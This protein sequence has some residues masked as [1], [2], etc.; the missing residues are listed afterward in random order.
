MKT[1][2]L[3]LTLLLLI[4]C[5]DFVAGGSSCGEGRLES[6]QSGIGGRSNKAQITE[7][8]A[9]CPIEK[10]GVGGV[11]TST[12]GSVSSTKIL[13]GEGTVYAYVKKN[14]VIC[15]QQTKSGKDILKIRAECR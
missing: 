1:L 13:Y 11:G 8:D 10:Y 6:W 7:I 15:D 4:S 12:S 3:S 2:I 9:P 5:A 14:G